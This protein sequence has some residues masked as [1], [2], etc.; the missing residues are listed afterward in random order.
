MN[1]TRFNDVLI[2]WRESGKPGA[3]AIV[4]VNSLGTDCRMW[5]AVVPLLND[6]WRVVSYDKRGHGLSD[7]PPGPYT[8][9][10]HADDLLALADHLKLEQ[11]A[12]VGL[13]IGGVIAQTVALRQPKRLRALVLADTAAKIG[14]DESW[15][16]RI[17][18]IRDHG[19]ES[20]ADAI[21]ERWFSRGYREANLVEL[22][23]WRNMM[24]RTPVAGYIASCLAL[25]SADL[26]GDVTGIAVPT[27]VVT[28]AEDSSTP[29]ELGRALADSIPGSRFVL[30]P[31]SG[32]LPAIEQPAALAALITRHMEDNDHV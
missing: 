18:A 27:L 31:A 10:D 16:A 12:L 7:M 11:F 4:L 15:N 13:S 30:I 29:P 22:A 21:M 20:I 6:R 3:P 32:H 1:F 17:N 19:F 24:L 2:H 9:D 14:N 23:G 5:D 28:G 8:I 25:K 26:T